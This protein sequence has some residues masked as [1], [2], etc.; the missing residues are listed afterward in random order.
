MIVN[1]KLSVQ[2]WGV[3]AGGGHSTSFKRTRA[4]NRCRE[5]RDGQVNC[6][7][8]SSL[9]FESEHPENFLKIPSQMRNSDSE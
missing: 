3:G 1:R 2:F 5:V 9:A 7:V 6:L 8:L 4:C